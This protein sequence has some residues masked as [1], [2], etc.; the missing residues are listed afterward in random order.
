MRTGLRLAAALALA[1]PLAGCDGSVFMSPEERLDEE[2]AADPA[3]AQ[4]YSTL[5]EEFPE[6]YSALRQTLLDSLETDRSGQSGYYGAQSFMLQFMSRNLHHFAASPQEHL[7]EVREHSIR[8]MEMVASEGQGMC[9]RYTMSG[10]AH[11]DVLSSRTEMQLSR[12]TVA[13][14]RAMAAGRDHPVKRGEAT[15]AD[16]DAYARKLQENGMTA[17]EVDAFFYGGAGL[18]GLSEAAQCRLGRAIYN[19]LADL[20]DDVSERLSAVILLPAA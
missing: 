14:V 17:E 10:L 19:A 4:L 15:E 11:D 13:Q 2:I 6:D 7:F 12:L 1:A 3:L 8:A 9:A 5:E 16:W 20:P 18:L